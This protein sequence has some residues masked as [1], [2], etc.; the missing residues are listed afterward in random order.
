[1]MWRIFMKFTKN[2][3]ELWDGRE[4]SASLKRN[5]DAAHALDAVVKEM[6]EQ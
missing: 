1:M 6:L 2:C 3:R 4:L 5:K